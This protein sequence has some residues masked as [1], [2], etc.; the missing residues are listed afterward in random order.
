[1]KEETALK[2]VHLYPEGERDRTDDIVAAIK[3]AGPGGTVYLH[4]GEYRL[5]SSFQRLI[6][7]IW[8]AIQFKGEQK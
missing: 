4:G 2:T 7:K 3:E 5:T 8:A 6:T 1:M